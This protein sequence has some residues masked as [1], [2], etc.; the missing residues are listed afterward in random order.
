[1][2]FLPPKMIPAFTRSLRTILAGGAFLLLSLS[3]MAAPETIVVW[4]PVQGTRQP[5]N[6]FVLDR[7][8][9]DLVSTWL[10]ESGLPVIRL[11]ST[12]L[13]SPTTFSSDA[14][15]ILIL[16]GDSFP[17]VNIEAIKR[18]L[19]GG[20]ILIGLDSR[21][22]FVNVIEQKAD[23]YWTLSPETP[24]FQWQS[25]ELIK[26]IGLSYIYDAARNDQTTRVTASPLLKKYLPAAP[27]AIDRQFGGMWIVP[28][29][30][31]RIY[32]LLNS[33]R[34][35]GSVVPPQ[36]FITEKEN[37]RALICLNG[38]FTS[39]KDTGAWSLGRE[40]V[41]TMAKIASDLRNGDLN[42]DRQ[43]IS[44]LQADLAPPEPLR[45]RRPSGSVDLHASAIVR[46]W[47]KFDGSSFELGDA[48]SKDQHVV[49]ATNGLFP[50]TLA[51]GASIELPRLT[52]DAS[53][54][55]ALRIR[56]AYL[57]SGA[58]LRVAAGKQVCW[59]ETFVPIDATGAGNFS[60]KT[61]G[62]LPIE[63]QRVTFVPLDGAVVIS[64]PGT[65]PL[66]FDAIQLEHISGEPVFI[67][68][69]QT[70][71]SPNTTKVPVTLTREWNLVRCNMRTNLIGPPDDPARFAATD[72]LFAGFLRNET[73]IQLL[74]EGT[75]KWAA[76][77]PERYSA[78]EK[79]GRGR[80]VPPD[81]EKYEQLVRDLIT[82]YGEHVFAYEVWNEPDIPQF[83]NG[84]PEEYASFLLRIAPV[85]R[86]LAPGKL[87]IS[88]GQAGYHEEF[89][90][91]V[92]ALGAFQVV[93]WIGFHPYAG[94]S[95]GW[96]VAYGR[97]EGKLYSLG[98]D[99]PIYCD[100]S[101]FV[102]RAGEWF[103]GNYDEAIQRDQLN[104]AV[105]RLMA[106][107]LTRLNLFHATASTH[108]FDLIDNDGK[109][110]PAYAVLADYVKL[111]Q[112]NGRRIAIGM[113]APNGSPLEGVYSIASL[114][115][116]GGITIVLNPADAPS[117]QPDR[118]SSNELDNAGGWTTF[119]GQ[120]EWVNGTA[121]IT[122]D[123]G[124]TSAGF[125][126]QISA[127]AYLRPVLEINVPACRGHWD[128]MLKFPDKTS[129]A[130]AT[131]QGAGLFKIN[132]RNLL[133]GTNVENA[134]LSFRIH[135]GPATFD[136]VR[137]GTEDGAKPPR[138]SPLPVKLIIP[139]TGPAT[140]HAGPDRI[141][142]I[143]KTAG[144][145]S[146]A[147]MTVPVTGRTV[148]TLTH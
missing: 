39:A 148:I 69:M 15:G 8:Y 134:E 143:N 100:E 115:D 94:T 65:E 6:R 98:L 142:V 1:M 7:A 145:S 28:T 103:K 10:K 20:G 42:L 88:A 99:K 9:L 60:S 63:F 122:P 136:Y 66:Y 5:A 82:R 80:A 127:N 53:A 23:G 67:G 120:T 111:G 132:Y 11:D 117:L 47:G 105:G 121:V 108:H 45:I 24:P 68:P 72:K 34:A 56:G 2:Q 133:A 118:D 74:L 31:T 93:D 33:L 64:N 123:A 92:H 18:F 62:R 71:L 90:N 146:W 112:R 16:P 104:T 81:P 36:I 84:T 107:S 29:P 130:L 110:R 79:I 77:S 124:R 95:A 106:D 17:K 54:T 30:G 48:T 19:D 128:L 83:W 49:L 76:I 43:E 25:Q 70:D 21:I 131:Q 109:P 137:F 126:T 41:V 129:V 87:I 3:S 147:E 57:G 13:N 89:I 38:I 50:H 32:P 113:T 86:E 55:L 119:W 75:P 97:F 139:W 46:R 138:P 61:E 51:P 114:H 125:Y 144:A 40:T 58:G 73:R 140:A 135:G 26:Y 12:A 4:E 101:G 27:D 85:I 78:G 14:Q 22:P 44:T 102:F 141:P 91:K 59:N 52:A 37:R 35:D 116:G 96:D